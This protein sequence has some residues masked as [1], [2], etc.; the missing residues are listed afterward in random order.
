MAVPQKVKNGISTGPSNPVGVHTQ[1]NDIRDFKR[2]AH[3]RSQQHSSRW[4]NRGSNPVSVDGGRM[5][6]MW[7]VHTTEYHSA[8]KGDSDTRDYTDEPEDTTRRER[9]V[10]RDKHRVTPLP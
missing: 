10:M 7:C 1:K 3:P 2:F 4:P 9:A 5:H 6:T 8:P